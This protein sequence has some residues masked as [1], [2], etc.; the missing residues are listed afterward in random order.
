METKHDGLEN[1]SDSN[2]AILGMVNFRGVPLLNVL[3]AA[4]QE[5]RYLGEEPLAPQLQ[6]LHQPTPVALENLSQAIEVREDLQQKW[7]LKVL[8]WKQTA[9]D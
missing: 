5:A 6:G 2:W 8:N 9:F 4:R 1:L 3:E 7:S